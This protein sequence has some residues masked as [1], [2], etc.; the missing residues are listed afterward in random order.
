MIAD[1]LHAEL[2]VVLAHKLRSLL[3]PETAF[4]AVGEDGQVYLNR[5]I[6]RVAGM[7]EAYLEREQQTQFD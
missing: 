7:T 3:Q 4:G 1:A 2:D 6:S 5:H